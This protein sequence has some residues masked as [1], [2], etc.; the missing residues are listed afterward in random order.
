MDNGVQIS[1]FLTIMTF[2]WGQRITKTK[3]VLFSPA[4]V[5]KEE[6]S[7]IVT[8]SPMSSVN[9]RQVWDVYQPATKFSK[10]GLLLK[11]N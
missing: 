7:K 11:M 5:V 10:H 1:N 4:G 6:A 3:N 8:L 2:L 9:D